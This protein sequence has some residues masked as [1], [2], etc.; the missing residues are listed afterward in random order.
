MEINKGKEGISMFKEKQ[1]PK[2]LNLPMKSTIKETKASI[3]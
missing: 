1:L 3:V 2:Y